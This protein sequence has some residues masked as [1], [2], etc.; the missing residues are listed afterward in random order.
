MLIKGKVKDKSVVEQRNYRYAYLLWEF[1]KRDQELFP[2][3]IVKKKGS[4]KSR[5]HCLVFVFD[6]S[7][8]DIPNGEEETQFYKEIIEM[9]RLRK[10]HY[11]QIVLTCMDKVEE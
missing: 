5:P 7:M 2:S 4:L 1:W 3:K 9:A 6:G 8:D 10:Y 11:P